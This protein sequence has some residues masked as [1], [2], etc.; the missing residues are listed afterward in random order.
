MDL[1]KKIMTEKQIR[2][3]QLKENEAKKK[4]EK[5][6]QKLFERELVYNIQS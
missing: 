1:E 4:A 2:E 5:Q 3:K 6:A